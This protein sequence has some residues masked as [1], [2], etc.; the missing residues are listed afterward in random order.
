M[1]KLNTILLTINCTVLTMILIGWNTAGAQSYGTNDCSFYISQ[2]RNEVSEHRLEFV[3]Q[4][5]EHEQFLVQFI[6]QESETIQGRTAI[7]LHQLKTEL[8]P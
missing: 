7:M 6:R 4:M 2:L 8:S 3:Q 5:G 1:S